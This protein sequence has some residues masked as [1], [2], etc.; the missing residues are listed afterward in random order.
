[1]FFFQY[2]RKNGRFFLELLVIQL[3]N[4]HPEEGAKIFLEYGM[5]VVGPPLQF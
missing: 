1:M 5:K 2:I 3:L 4:Q